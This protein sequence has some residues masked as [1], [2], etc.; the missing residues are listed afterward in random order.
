MNIRTKS[1]ILLD[2]LSDSRI[3]K[4]K[5]DTAQN[6]WSELTEIGKY[7]KENF[8]RFLLLNSWIDRIYLSEKKKKRNL[9]V[10]TNN[11][12]SIYNSNLILFNS[13]FGT[14]R[15]SKNYNYN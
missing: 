8:E 6:L 4:Y 14:T 10:H 11:I 15:I 3:Y 5:I 1:F 2:H 12:Y 7:L 9:F 13:L